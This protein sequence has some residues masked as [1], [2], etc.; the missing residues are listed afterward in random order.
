M[1]NCNWALFLL[2][3]II[4]ILG[5]LNL[6]SAGSLRIE[7]G[8]TTIYYYKKQLLW[9]LIGFLGLLCFVSFDYRHLKSIAWPLFWITLI[10]LVGV[11]I[12][13][14]NICGAKRWI[15]CGIF[16]FQPTEV[17]KLST[18]IVTALLLSRIPTP[19]GWK[20]LGKM[21]AVIAMPLGLIVIQ[22]D[23]GSG[24]NILLLVAGM[25]LY[26]GMNPRVFWTV[27]ISTLLILPQSWFFL[28]EYQKQ[29]I[30]T[31]F[32]PESDPLGAGYNILQSQIAIGSGGLW[33][34]GFLGGTQSQLR[35]LPEKHTDFVFA[36]FGEEWGF[37]G[38]LLLVT[39]FCL[40]LNQFINIM[41]DSKDEF[42]KYLVAGIFFYFFWQIMINI[43]MVLGLM[44]VVGLP[45]PFLSYGG[46]STVMNFCLLGL[47]LNVSM[48]RYVFKQH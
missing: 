25:I 11:L 17:A 10:L 48:R 40:L 47:A 44:P 14:T 28:K 18:L 6:Y 31:F 24:M 30:L 46:S 4:F 22:P 2:A 12:V 39:I 9:G 33:G 27:L 16:Y 26:K 1:I 13:G 23:L 37:L 36:V 35:F 3:M 21:M 8:V 34:K 7:D 5:I 41:H 15:N 43:S 42:G 19:L 45:L 32:N 38:S 20:E 29:R